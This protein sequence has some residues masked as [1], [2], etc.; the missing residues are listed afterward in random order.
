MPSVLCP[1]DFSDPSR[2]ALRYA[3]AVADHFGA[4]LTIVTVADPL[5]A[6][7]SR[8]TGRVPSLEQETTEE[9]RR[10]SSDILT[11][12]VGPK[13][14]EYMVAVGK[15]ATEI[16]RA[17]N[18]LKAD[19]IVISSHGRS[20]L[21][22]LFFGSTTERVLR[23]TSVPVLVTPDDG[24]PA[25]S[26][27]EIARHINR[28]VVPVD[29]SGALSPQVS[30]AAGIA[31]ALSVPLILT[32]VL[33]PVFVPYGVRLA[34]PG[35]EA[36]RRELADEKLSAVAAAV[37]PGIS[38]ESLVLVGEPSEEIARL[39]DVR[40]ANLIVIGLHSSGFLGPRM[41]SVTY[42]VLCLT[43]ALVLAIPPQPIAAEGRTASTISTHATT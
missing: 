6:Q 42:R 21:R 8:E 22:H 14:V 20:G 28:I 26:L 35:S 12:A 30:I 29:L 36:A 39:A 2:A 23:E 16:L 27:S 5:L 10:F 1:V 25:A 31:E 4:R 18:T 13:T 19:L 37:K 40:G 7:V 43:H 24:K 33:E 9:L 34:I 3:S 11:L 38:T 17:A 41:G 32:H 15:P